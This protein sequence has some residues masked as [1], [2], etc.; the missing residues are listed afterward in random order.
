MLAKSFGVANREMARGRITDQI[1]QNVMGEDLIQA[2]NLSKIAG[3][4]ARAMVLMGKCQFPS[5][6]SKSQA[7]DWFLIWRMLNEQR[8]ERN[9]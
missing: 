5:Y 4:F 2:P 3:I 6:L 8:M 1:K 9:G 7:E